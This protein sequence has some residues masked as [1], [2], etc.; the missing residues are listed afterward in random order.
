MSD[1]APITS[2]NSLAIDG[3]STISGSIESTR[4]L[5]TYRDGYLSRSGLELFPDIARSS[6]RLSVNVASVPLAR[7]HLSLKLG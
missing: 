3:K 7:L 2:T 1:H 6:Y 5:L 4:R